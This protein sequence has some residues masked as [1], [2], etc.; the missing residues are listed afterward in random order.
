MAKK[1]IGVIYGRKSREKAATLESQ[2]AAC[3][4]WA[5]RNDIEIDFIYQEEG[6]SSS[7][8][9]N[10]PQLQEMIKHI[11]NQ[12]YHIVI[13][14]EQTRISRTEDFGQFKKIMRETGTIFV[15]AD[16]S[17]VYDFNNKH[18]A[19]RSGINQVF[20]EYELST[21]KTRLKRGTVQAAKKGD[22]Q[23]KKAPVGYDYDKNSKRLVQNKDAAVVRRIFEL[24]LSG[25]ST[26]EIS[27]II[28]NIEKLVAYHKVKDVMV[29]ITWSKSTIARTLKNIAY[30]GN[31]LFGKTKLKKIKGKKLKE[32][33]EKEQQ[34]FVEGTH[35]G[36]VTKEEFEQV[37]NMLSSKRNQPPALKHAKHVFSGLIACANCGKHHTFEKQMDKNKE[38]RISSCSTKNYNEDYSKHTTC[39]N[40]GCKLYLVEKLFYASLEKIK[41]DIEN[42][43]EI[44]KE[45][46]ITD[47][48]SKKRK[49]A[50]RNAKTAKLQALKRKRKNILEM[51]E[52]GD[53]EGEEKIEKKQQTK[54]MMHEIK[55]LENEIEE[56]DSFEEETEA[57]QLE[58]VLDNLKKFLS[59]KSNMSE[60]EQNEILKEFLQ[61]IVY[62][63]AG[64]AAEIKIE[65]HMKENVKE[66]LND[67]IYSQA[68]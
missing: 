3:K 56:I 64:K 40:S 19:V 11:E 14:S 62:S 34:I 59:G 4:D 29:P 18:D 60:K 45:R 24:Y 5:I 27:N 48:N 28:T 10:R 44:V 53:Y 58:R 54:D 7:E 57:K 8:D 15:E 25:K 20:G 47:K 9:W 31:T 43:I 41:N 68:S 55:Q 61:D 2:I 42:Y 22:Y 6:D 32:A 65:I 67:T 26:T 21:A 37:Q 33:T 51:I 49:E 63:K 50:A 39:G 17:T 35:K 13:V 66:I 52:D 36:I 38:W 46:K 30:S 1:K 23:G 16:T 12:E